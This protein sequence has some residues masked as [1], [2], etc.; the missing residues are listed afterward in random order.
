MASAGVGA[1]LQD[2][3]DHA[4]LELL[5]QSYLESV[6]DEQAGDLRRTL[7]VVRAAIDIALAEP[8]AQRVTR[9]HVQEAIARTPLSPPSAL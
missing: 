6:A 2:V 3:L 7:S 5:A 8:T 1:A 9:G 4:G